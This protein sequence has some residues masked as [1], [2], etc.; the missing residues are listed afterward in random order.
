MKQ[1]KL[2]EQI[3]DELKE[4]AK[5]LSCLYNVQEILHDQD[6][7]S[8][9]VIQKIADAIPPGFQYPEIT[10]ARIVSPMGIYTSQ[11]FQ[12]TPWSI[13]VDVEIKNSVIGTISVYYTKEMPEFDEGPFLKEER[14]LLKSI[15]ERIGLQIYHEQLQSASNPQKE[16]SYKAEWQIILDMLSQTNPKLLVK[17]SRKMIN[18][19]CWIGI[20]EAE[21]LMEQFSPIFEGDIQFS[22]ELNK[23]FQKHEDGDMI[24]L[25]YEI[26]DLAGKNISENEVL[27]DIQKWTR[28]D[29]SGFLSE[30]LENNGSSLA[31]IGMSLERYYHMDQEMAELSP[32]RKKSFIIALVKRILTGQQSLVNVAKQ[33]LTLNDF[34]KLMDN[35]ISPHESYGKIGGKG[36][37]LF[38]AKALLNKESNQNE[39]ISHIK[40][41]KTWHIISD[42]LLN[43]MK[44]NDIDEVIEQKY[45]ELGQVRQ[46][47]PYVIQLFKNSLHSPEIIKGLMVTL[48]DLGEVPLIVRS[49]SLLEDS[50]GTAFAG[51]YKSLFI[52]NQGSKEKRLNEL[53]DAISEV[54][55]STFGPD[56][57]EYRSNYDLLDFHEEM[58]ILIQ[59]VV[60]T[61]VGNYYLPAFSGVAFS[62]NEFRWSS[63]IKSDDGLVRLVPGLGTR[64][65][66]RVSDDYPVLLSPGQP[67]L[68]VNV[69]VDEVIRYSPQNIDVIN[70][71]TETFETVSMEDILR[72]Y[73]KEY[74]ML[75]NVVSVVN[76]KFLRPAHVLR[77]DFN[78]DYFVVN[79]DGLIKH[80]DFVQRLRETMLVL[81]KSYG[82]PVDIEFAHNGTDFYLLQ[83]R[84]QSHDPWSKPAKM[85]DLIDKQKVV[86]TADKY[87]SNGFISG[88]KY[89]V[90]VNPEAYSKMKDYQEL[91]LVGKAIGILNQMLPKRQFILMG[92]GRWGS[93]GDVKLGVRV[94]Y[95]DINNTAMLI[96]IARKKNEYLPEV[97]FGTHFFQDLVEANIKYL[98]LYPDE[99]DIIFNEDILEASNIFSKL[100]PDLKS[101]ENVVRVI[102]MQE[103]Y[104]GCELNV[105]MNSDL[106]KALGYIVKQK[107]WDEKTTILPG[108]V[109]HETNNDVHWQ[110]R[111]RNA[112]RIAAKLDPERFGVVGF[113]LFGSTENATAREESDI[114][115]IIHFRGTQKQR[116]DL[117]LWLEGWSLSLSQMNLE[118]TGHRTSG[119]L[120]VHL[121]TDEDI[122]A[123]TSYAFKIGAIT[124]AARPLRMGTD[125]DK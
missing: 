4:R 86:F 5:E 27:E 32:P 78:K 81:E 74:P 60:G 121:V 77:T 3:F 12:E 37:G 42:G 101:I 26:F 62:R 117:L 25:A 72:K 125:I 70:L 23:P 111:L 115:L 35:I 80:T 83:C 67:E 46:E 102:D 31:K 29:R 84:Y 68:R 63:R 109:M 90:Y 57:I 53:T 50:V 41:P 44:Y 54:Y 55:A 71:E 104:E 82:Y 58:G 1:D 100:I 106:E 48:D 73:G 69:S 11:N 66:D 112:E 124:D 51:K 108:N 123:R 89:I 65:V 88:I 94:S 87:I 95:S 103:I 36:A 19:L 98:P 96:E 75:E 9:E 43:F 10:V 39:L 24:K 28:E 64:A 93:R 110:W 52:A 61:R 16:S 33:A 20:P 40:I 13:H 116:E 122:K 47:Y 8:G 79:F 114:D 92:P 119:L 38:I 34:H 21:K 76:Q 6:N 118:R 7:L 22:S 17:L 97:S 14:R 49:S 15:A 45:K 85:P 59:E 120:D 113:Y 99:W 30:I 56:P 105:F 91:M 107:E 18:H 2:V